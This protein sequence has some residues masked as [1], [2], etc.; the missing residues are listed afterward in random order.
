MK[1][2]SST[3]LAALAILSACAAHQEP[4]TDPKAMMMADEL[5]KE[6][7]PPGSIHR[8]ALDE[9]LRAGPSWLL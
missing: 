2:P 7:A 6:E 5:P 1:G 8:A 9:I 3:L 4:P